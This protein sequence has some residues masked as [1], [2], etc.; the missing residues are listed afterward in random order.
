MNDKINAEVFMFC[1][2][3][4]ASY[5]DTICYEVLFDFIVQSQ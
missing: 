1:Q 5:S 4:K 2:R 3:R